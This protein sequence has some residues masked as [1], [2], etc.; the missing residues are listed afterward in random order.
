MVAAAGGWQGLERLDNHYVQPHLS[1]VV[2][3]LGYRAADEWE[4]PTNDHA[5][6]PV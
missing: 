6:A 2:R 1:T 4:L 3:K 5:A